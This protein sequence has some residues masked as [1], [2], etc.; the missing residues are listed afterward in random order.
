MKKASEQ[1]ITALYCRLSCDDGA[2]GDSNSVA[3]Q[4]SICQGEILQFLTNNK[5]MAF[6]IRSFAIVSQL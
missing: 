5:K 4:D 1:G 2:E 3:N 6:G